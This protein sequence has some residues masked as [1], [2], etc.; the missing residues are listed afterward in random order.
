MPSDNEIDWYALSNGLS[1]VMPDGTLVHGYQE[2][3]I[4]DSEL[5]KNFVVGDKVKVTY[6]DALGH[7]TETTGEIHRG[8]LGEKE[9]YYYVKLGGVAVLFPEKDIQYAQG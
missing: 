8:P 4:M 6:I 9:A 5:K 3:K 7:S 2:E 1:V